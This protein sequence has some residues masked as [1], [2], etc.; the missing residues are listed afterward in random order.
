M[1]RSLLIGKD[2]AAVRSLSSPGFSKEPEYPTPD[3]VAPRGKKIPGE[4]T[5]V[6][7]CTPFWGRSDEWG[8][9]YL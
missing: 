8:T 2:A 3:P 6:D 7:P 1:V 9:K 5:L 4:R